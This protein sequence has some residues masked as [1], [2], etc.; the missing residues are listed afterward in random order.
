VLR[1]AVL[2]AWAGT[3]WEQGALGYPTSEEQPVSGGTRTDFQRGSIT[4][5]T[6]TGVA[7]VHVN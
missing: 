2:D 7:T 6:A 4:V 5:S 3:G 1:G